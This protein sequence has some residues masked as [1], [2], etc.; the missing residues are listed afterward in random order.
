MPANKNAQ[1]RYIIIDQCLCRRN[2]YWTIQ[3][4][5]DAINK[6]YEETNGSGNGVS[7]RTLREDLKNMRSLTHHNAPIAYTLQLGYHYTDPDFSI[8]K[9]SLTSEDLVL[10]HQSLYTLKG[11]RGF[12]LADDLDELIIRLERHVPSA[13]SSTAP[14]LQLEVAPDYSGT[15]FLKPLYKAIR[16][17]KSVVLHYKPYRAAQVSPESIHPQLLKAYNGRWF[18]VAL[19]ETR[20][21]H[22][23]NYALDRI[24]SID[25]S[26]LEF[27]SADIDFSSYFDSLIGVTIPENNPGVE[28]IHLHIT[29]GRA[30]YVRTKPLHKSQRIIKNTDEGMEIELRLI[31]NQ[32]LKTLLLSFGADIKVLTPTSLQNSMRGRLKK[33]LSNYV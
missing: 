3:D 14:I 33:A 6:D 13:G 32:E 16:E 25:D 19:N 5:L 8:F 26:Q 18:L 22:L 21:S 27:R 10:L 1:N 24:T 15:P 12:G 2:R 17:K 9:S 28:T 31:I 4:L 29:V 7:L 30:P 11:L 23:Q 20:G